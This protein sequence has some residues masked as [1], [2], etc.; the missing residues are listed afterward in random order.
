MNHGPWRRFTDDGIILF[1]PQKVAVTA[2]DGE[3]HASR[4]RGHEPIPIAESSI[5]RCRSD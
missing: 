2:T 4:R 1:S 3:P 5:E